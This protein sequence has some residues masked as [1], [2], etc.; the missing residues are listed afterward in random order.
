MAKQQPNIMVTEKG[1]DDIGSILNTL[2]FEWKPYN[3]TEFEGNGKPDLLFVNCG[4]ITGRND[5]GR[6][7]ENGGVVYIS[8]HAKPDYEAIISE[9]GKSCHIE[10]EADSGSYTGHITDQ[11]LS[12]FIG[13]DAIELEFDTDAWAVVHQPPEGAS[14][15]MEVEGQPV[16]MALKHGLG[17]VIFTSFHNSVQTTDVEKQL[18]RYLALKPLMKAKSIRTVKETTKRPG[19]IRIIDESEPVIAPQATFTQTFS[20]PP[21]ARSFL[22]ELN[23]L[24]DSEVWI[25][26][27]KAGSKV[28]ATSGRMAPLRL[29]VDEVT[30]SGPLE[31]R[32]RL[33]GA[34]TEALLASMVCSI[35]ESDD[36][37]RASLRSLLG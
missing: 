7:I 20:I 5:L 13:R 37:D 4:N 29:N 14:I 15:L 9:I 23:W 24:G 6:F 28:G 8:D 1:W 10:L 3:S 12:A 2:G 11:S 27:W 17:S 36:D 34:S 25:E 22:I 21:S 30:P 35:T 19:K 33:G 26:V 18:I 16:V 32:L 31:V